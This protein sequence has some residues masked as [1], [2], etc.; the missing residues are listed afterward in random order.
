MLLFHSSMAFLLNVANFQAVKEEGPLMMNVVGN[1]KQVVMVI[2]SVLI[3]GQQMKLV[4]II[5]S[6]ICICG[7]IWYSYGRDGH[8]V[9][10]R[11][12]Q[13]GKIE[14]TTSSISFNESRMGCLFQ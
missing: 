5:G 12:C 2:L 7:S 9:T 1:L 6:I 4:G 8:L 11:K 3:F 13:N 10:C 14:G